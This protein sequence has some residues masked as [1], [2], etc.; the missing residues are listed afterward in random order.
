MA[1]MPTAGTARRGAAER[2]I[3]AALVGIVANISTGRGARQSGPL[4][5][6]HRSECATERFVAVGGAIRVSR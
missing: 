2:R 1:M 6:G 3:R 5:S 4:G